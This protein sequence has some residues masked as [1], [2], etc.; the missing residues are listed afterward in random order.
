MQP[1]ELMISLNDDR[2]E[3]HSTIEQRMTE[4]EYKWP[5]PKFFGKWP[6]AL[7]A[8]VFGRRMGLDIE[9]YP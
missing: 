4:T 6:S 9:K 5:I 3:I 2:N 1:P 7:A 8:Y